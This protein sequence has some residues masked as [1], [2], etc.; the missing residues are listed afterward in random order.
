LLFGNASGASDSIAVLGC[1]SSTGFKAQYFYGTANVT[2]AVTAGSYSTGPLAVGASQMLKL[3]I[4]VSSTTPAGRV[5]TCAVVAGSSAMPSHRDV[6][7]AKVKV[8]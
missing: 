3:T 1:T 7:Q 8:G 5:E 6:V 4:A 2:S